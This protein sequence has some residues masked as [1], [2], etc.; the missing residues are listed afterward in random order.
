MREEEM[1]AEIE[2]FNHP[3]YRG[4]EDQWGSGAHLE[5]PARLE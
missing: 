2:G 4:I 5:H 1:L 3:T